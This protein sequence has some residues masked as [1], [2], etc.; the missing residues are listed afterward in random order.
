MAKSTTCGKS[1][2]RAAIPRL[3][4][5]LGRQVVRDV[6]AI[7]IDGFRVGYRP[8]K[9]WEYGAFA[10]LY[11]NP[12]SRSLD[13]DYLDEGSLPGNAGGGWRLCGLQQ[14]TQ[15]GRAGCSYDRVA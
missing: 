8:R 11:P 2:L 4:M 15:F 13:T 9:S 1:T 6:D 7:T 3:T 5:A 10:G 14:R 12:F